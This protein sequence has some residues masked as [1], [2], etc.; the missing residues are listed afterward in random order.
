MPREESSS[1]SLLSTVALQSV[2]LR[3]SEYQRQTLSIK[4]VRFRFID[5]CRRVGMNERAVPAGYCV[6]LSSLRLSSAGFLRFL[7]HALVRPRLLVAAHGERS[8]MN[9]H[10]VYGESSALDRV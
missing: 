10:M 4:R 3:V 8:V 1:P 6:N 5:A 9:L 2:H 7:G